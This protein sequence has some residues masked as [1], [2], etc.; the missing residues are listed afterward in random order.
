[1]KL[2]FTKLTTISEDDALK[3]VL[4]LAKSVGFPGTSFQ[5]G[6][7]GYSILRTTAS[8]ISSVSESIQYI[9]SLIYLDTA[10]NDALDLL[11][12][13]HFST[14]RF[15][16]TQTIIKCLIKNNGI[17]AVS[18][19]ADEVQIK[20][21][22]GTD[23]NGEEIYV[24]F[25][26][27]STFNINPS[28]QTYVEFISDTFGASTRVSQQN[29]PVYINAI[30][31]TEF[32][33]ISQEDGYFFNIQLGQEKETDADYRERCKNK[34]ATISANG[35]EDAYKYWIKNA[36]NSEGNNVN[37]TRILIDKSAAEFTGVIVIYCASDDG[38]PLEIDLEAAQENVDKYRPINSVAFVDPCIERDLY[39][40]L[41]IT[42]NGND[43]DNE[44]KDLIYNSIKEYLAS[45]EIGGTL[46]NDGFSY[47]LSSE[48]I[49]A[50]MNLNTVV[51][52]KI[53]GK[54]LDDVSLSTNDI[55][56]NFSDVCKLDELN[57]K[58]NTSILR[59]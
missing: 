4:D 48:I 40:Q 20:I 12:Q 18:K 6:S 37:I 49:D 7:I 36:I 51:D 14:S 11:C 13:N 46:M 47:V 17:L 26:N 35:P 58:A 27:T 57:L 24:N 39:Y 44:L 43:T 9:A 25:K 38:I 16:E 52:C 54:Y 21:F 10:T 22:Y 5:S 29:L 28:S 15:Q 59:V 32:V 31:L 50:I 23:V 45:L 41:S 19:L 55:K 3:Y 42:S 56:L 53:T 33:N 34:W 1:M 2:D 30:P 8:V